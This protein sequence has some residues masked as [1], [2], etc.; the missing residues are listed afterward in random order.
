LKARTVR[1]TT[2]LALGDQDKA[3]EDAALVMSIDLLNVD[4][5]LVEAKVAEGRGDLHQSHVLIARAASIRPSHNVVRQSMA[6]SVAM[7]IYDHSTLGFSYQSL[8][9]P[10]LA[11]REFRLA[12][13]KDMARVDLRIALAEAIWEQGRYDEAR[14]ECRLVLDHYPRCLRAMLIMAHILVEQGRAAHGIEMMERANEMDPECTIAVDLYAKAPVSRMLLPPPPSLPEP[15]IFEEGGAVTREIRGPESDASNLEISITADASKMPSAPALVDIGNSPVSGVSELSDIT[16]DTPA[17]SPDFQVSEELGDT[18]PRRPFVTSNQGSFAN[19]EFSVNEEPQ[20]PVEGGAAVEFSAG[21]PA[22]KRRPIESSS[23]LD[24]QHS[25]SRPE[26]EESSHLEMGDSQGTAAEPL[27]QTTAD[28]LPTADLTHQTDTLREP[29]VADVDVGKRVEIVD[30]ALDGRWENVPTKVA[31]L[32]V[33]VDIDMAATLV[34]ELDLLPGCPKAIWKLLG[35]EYMR[36]RQS[37]LASEAYLRA[38][39]R[40]SE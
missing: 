13:Q 35:D 30:M 26:L 1:A 3:A 31:E 7:L 5:L 39:Q 8:N 17:Q 14:P 11:E 2:W 23:L 33:D 6:D 24:T 27:S 16:N 29:V 20:G 12:L 40:A 25:I 18:A 10:D 19:K 15:P 21:W 32:F 22:G 4:A 38:V 28:V 36:N 37:D 9:W 34:E